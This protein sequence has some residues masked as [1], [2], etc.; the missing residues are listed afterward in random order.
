WRPQRLSPALE[1]HHPRLTHV[2]VEIRVVEEGDPVA[3]G[4]ETGVGDPSV[5]LEENLPHWRLERASRPNVAND[6]ELASWAPVGEL[7]VLHQTPGCSSGCLE[8]GERSSHR[9]GTAESRLEQ[10]S[11]GPGGS[12]SHQ[13][14]VAQPQRL[15]LDAGGGPAEHLL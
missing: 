4:R 14:R 10:Q 15:R 8:A 12:H 11:E 5:G 9:E 3:P 7:D 2:V 6:R 13:P 1:I